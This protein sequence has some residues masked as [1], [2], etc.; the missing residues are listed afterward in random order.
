MQSRLCTVRADACGSLREPG[1]CSACL[2]PQTSIVTRITA[3]S[4]LSR[5]GVVGAGLAHQEL[6]DVKSNGCVRDAMLLL[7]FAGWCVRE[8]ITF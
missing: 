1:S 3:I 4:P 2:V 8:L 6:Y 7:W 5:G